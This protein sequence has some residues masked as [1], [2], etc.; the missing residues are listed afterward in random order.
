MNIILVSG[1]SARART[2]TL[3]WP[4]WVGGSF[5]FFTLLILLMIPFNYFALKWAD[6]LHVKRKQTDKGRILYVPQATFA[7]HSWIREAIATDKPYDEFARDVLTATGDEVR[8]PVGGAE[9]PFAQPGEQAL[10][11]PGF[12]AG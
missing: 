8:H 10:Q 4:H 12:Q 2:I 6:I 3:E 1:A 5:A 11:H 9:V 7:F